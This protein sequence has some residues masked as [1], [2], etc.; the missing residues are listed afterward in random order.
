M[1]H[2]IKSVGGRAG[3]ASREGRSRKGGAMGTRTSIWAAGAALVIMLGSTLIFSPAAGASS[4][5]DQGVTAKTIAVGLPYVNFQALKSLGVT[6]DDG[7]FPDSS[8]SVIS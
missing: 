6:I 5:A 2:N 8:Q 3:S 7:T 1:S 4:P